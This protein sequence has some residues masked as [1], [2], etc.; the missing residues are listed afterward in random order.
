[1]RRNYTAICPF[2]LRYATICATACSTLVV[3]LRMCISAR[4]GASYGALTPVKSLI[5]PARAFLYRPFGSRRSAAATEMSTHTSMKGSGASPEE[6][7]PE[8]ACRARAEA[9]SAA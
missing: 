6:A 8:E 2:S 3:S 7:A 4:S 5:S 9:R 1:M